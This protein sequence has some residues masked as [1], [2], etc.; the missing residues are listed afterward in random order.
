MKPKFRA[1][2]DDPQI[3]FEEEFLAWLYDNYNIGNGD[4]LLHYLEDGGYFEDW[5]KDHYPD[6][7]EADN[8]VW[9]EHQARVKKNR[10]EAKA[11]ALNETN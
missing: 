3:F 9:E 11:R 1:G 6:E 2:I 4:M 10:D 5:F 8:K 7:W